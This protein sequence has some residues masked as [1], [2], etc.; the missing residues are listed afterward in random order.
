MNRCNVNEEE[1]TEK[2]KALIAQYQVSAPE[3]QSNLPRNPGLMEGVALPKPL[4]PDQNLENFGLPA[5]PSGG[6]KKI[7]AKELPNATN[8]DGSIQFPNSMKKTM[9]ASVKSRSLNDVNQ[10]PLPSEPDLQQLSK[11]SDMAVEKRKHKYREK[12][13][14]LEP[15]TGGGMAY[16]AVFFLCAF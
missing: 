13:R 10:S 6:K 7:G 12:H 4:N 2:T 9:Q 8:K 3:S 14:D 5:M 15:S 1:T 11:S 16:E